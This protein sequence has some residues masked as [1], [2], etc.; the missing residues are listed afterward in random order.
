MGF[1]PT[2][3]DWWSSWSVAGLSLLHP[4]LSPAPAAL[5]T[6]HIPI[7]LRHIYLSTDEPPTLTGFEQVPRHERRRPRPSPLHPTSR[8]Y[9]HS[10]ASF[11]SPTPS[12]EADDEDSFLGGSTMEPDDD[13]PPG[14]GQ[15]RPPYPGDD[16]RPTSKKE[17]AGWYSYGWAAEVFAVCAV[18]MF[19]ITP[20]RCAFRVM[21]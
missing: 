2:L 14:R 6:R 21:S 10:K 9:S 13:D 4:S 15:G 16:T 3:H 12:F 20:D 5:P 8:D 19:V 18:G 1:F 11:A 17:L 7:R